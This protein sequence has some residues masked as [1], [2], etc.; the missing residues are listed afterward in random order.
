FP[1]RHPRAPRGPGP[2]RVGSAPPRRPQLKAPANWD[3][4]RNLAVVD[5]PGDEGVR[6][7]RA[8]PGESHRLSR[9]RAVAITST[10]PIRRV[11]L[12]GP[13][14]RCYERVD[15]IAR[16][17]A[18]DS[19]EDI[20]SAGLHGLPFAIERQYIAGRRLDG[21]GALGERGNRIALQEP[22][23]SHHVVAP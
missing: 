5:I 18:A 6:R 2:A 23:Q 14:D 13:T 10:L 19:S 16:H 12:A 3:L 17:G 9:G 7:P 15:P 22:D 21:G 11:E 20:G 4:V 8:Q 1:R